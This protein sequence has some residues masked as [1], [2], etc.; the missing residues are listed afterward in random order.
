MMAFSRLRFQ[1]LKAVISDDAQTARD[2]LRLAHDGGV[3]AGFLTPSPSGMRFNST[4]MNPGT[5]FGVAYSGDEVVASIVLIEDGPFGLPS[6]RAFVEEIDMFR[7][8]GDDVFE[9]AAWVIAKEWRR[10]FAMVVRVLFGTVIRMN[11][12]AGGRRRMI[13]VVEP[14]RAGVTSEL[15]ALELMS[16]PRPY[17]EIP[18][19][20]LVTRP[21]SEW[22]DHYIGADAGFIPSR[23]AQWVFDPDPEWMQVGRE[24]PHWSTEVL[25]TLLAESDIERRL[26]VQL[27]I[28]RNAKLAQADVVN[29]AERPRR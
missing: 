10:H 16:E 5:M 20:L 28:V 15:F 21:V 17:L 29:E 8:K 22:A 25:P 9:V 23:M 7:K 2:A 13:F 19:T 24:G 3:E 6:D 18:G 27:A 26:E 14:Q 4:F 11:I 1:N 12:A